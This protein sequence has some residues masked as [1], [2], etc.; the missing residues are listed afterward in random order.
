MAMT[1]RT[2]LITAMTLSLGLLPCFFSVNIATAKDNHAPNGNAYGKTAKSTPTRDTKAAQESKKLAGDALR[3]CQRKQPDISATM[4]RIGATGSDQ[5]EAIHT[6]AEKVKQFYHDK[7]YTSAGYDQAVAETDALYNTA[8]S[9][10]TSLQSFGDNWSCA[11][12]TPREGIG[13]FADAKKA[14]TVALQ[15]YKDK[16]RTLILLLKEARS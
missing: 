2:T 7:Q 5:L 12:D 9:S 3:A 16:V 11:D 1:R 15:A 8:R 4:S 13:I 6:V 14:E 10:L